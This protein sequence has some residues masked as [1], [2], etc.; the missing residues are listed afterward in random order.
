MADDTK[1]KVLTYVVL[2]TTAIILI[3]ADLPQLVLSAGIPLP[4][5]QVNSEAALTETFP[6]AS[7]TLNTYFKALLSVVL[8]LV[9][10][11]CAYELIKGAHLADLLRP[12]LMIAVFGLIALVILFAISRVRITLGSPET[13]TLPPELNIIGP[14]LAPIPPNL[15]WLVWIGL[16]VSIAFL[17]I[18]LIR[19]QASRTLADDPLEKEADRAVQALRLGLDLRNVILRCYRQMSLALQ[20]E[21]G[22]ELEE[23]MTAREFERLLEARGIPRPPVQQLTLLFETARYG[24]QPPAPGDEQKAVDCLNAIV[25][26]SR[27]MRMLHRN[28]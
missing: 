15:V 7:I 16:I 3:A 25:Q 19:W 9:V 11:Y 18:W 14:P 10:A 27:A 12:S 6:A 22:I 26:S 13:E 4:G 23:T 20:K 28:E 24:C 5:Q 17:G 1:R 2:L 21:Q 8:I